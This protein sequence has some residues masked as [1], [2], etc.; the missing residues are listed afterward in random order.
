MKKTILNAILIGLLSIF[1]VACGGAAGGGDFEEDPGFDQEFGEQEGNDVGDEQLE[2]VDEDDFVEED[3]DEVDDED[4][5]PVEPFC[6]DGFVD[7]GEA[8]DDGNEEDGDGCSSTCEEEVFEAE[9]DGEIA[10]HIAVDDLGSNTAPA[11]AECED[12]IALTITDDV[13]VG[14][15]SCS[16]TAN[17]LEYSMLANVDGEGAVEGEIIVTLNGTPHALVLTGTLENGLLSLQFNDVTL[18]TTRLRAI[19]DGTI[20]AEFD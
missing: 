12:T 9:T 16:L 19:W 7:D 17:F 10:I 5:E 6:G 3:E 20:V 1:T 2:D 13:L 15:G 18:I 14:D 11:T 4:E 8:C